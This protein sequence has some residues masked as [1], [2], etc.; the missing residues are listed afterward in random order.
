MVTLLVRDGDRVVFVS[1]DPPF[2]VPLAD[3]AALV[4]IG[5]AVLASA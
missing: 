2:G 1:S 4:A 3:D 5:E